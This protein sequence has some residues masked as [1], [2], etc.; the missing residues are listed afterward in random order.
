MHRLHNLP[1]KHKLSG[2]IMLTSLTAL[3]LACLGFIAHEHITFRRTMVRD[4]SI[5]SEVIQANVAPGLTFDD[6]KAMEETLHSLA[7]QEH[8][9]AA[10]VYDP[11][12]TRVAAYERTGQSHPF[13][14]AVQP[15]EGTHFNRDRLEAFRPIN[16]AGEVIGSLYIASD[17]DELAERRIRY[18]LAAGL[19]LVL[20]G[21]VAFLLSTRLQR[22]ISGPILGLAQTAAR[23]ATEQ[24]YSLRATK[25]GHD[26]LGS[27]IDRFNEMLEQIQKQAVSLREANELLELRVKERT[28]ELWEESAG[29]QRAR[30]ELTEAQHR[31]LE[32]S[33]QAGMAEVATSVLHNVGNV[34]NS[35][36]VSAEIVEGKVRQTRADGLKRVAG[37]LHEHAADL[38]GFF[39]RDPRGAA[40]PD[41][42]LK[43]ADHLGEPNQ[44]ILQELAGLRKNVEHIKEIVAMQQR[45]A[46]GSGV[47]ETLTVEEL[48]ED[49]LRINAAGF[50]RHD[51]TLVREFFPVPPIITDRHKMLQILVNL[52][53]NAKY[54]LAK[55]AGEK[56]LIVRV[57]RDGDNAVKIE[58]IDNGI[59]IAPENLT[60]IFRHGFTTK[61]EGHGFGLHSG[62]LAAT[63][64]GGRLTAHSD[65]VGHGAVFSLELPLQPPGQHP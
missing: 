15:P 58:V 23:V 19:L 54:A 36:G 18:A 5:L 7:A 37:L 51:V 25:H 14:W 45:H 27:L 42:L 29:H 38:P 21:V 44:G 8:I 64:L 10:A 63:E 43:L 35:V 65:G 56:R 17:L 49:A 30:R 33:R 24:N 4:L 31:L 48:V 50:S 12:G 3:L 1:I 62:A 28:R 41:Y 22:L 39:A 6:A 11:S 61:K 2:I 60:R 26:E 13:A 55:V 32:I 46:R 47:W 59:G 57:T 34:L 52:V 53:N 40:L 20:S 9:L 16:L